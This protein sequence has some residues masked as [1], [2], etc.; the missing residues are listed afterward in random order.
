MGAGERKTPL[1]LQRACHVFHL[2][3]IDSE[4]LEPLEEEDMVQELLSVAL[5][6][7]DGHGEMALATL[8]VAMNQLMPSCSSS[9]KKLGFDKT[10]KFFNKYV[11]Q[12]GAVVETRGEKNHPWIVM[13]PVEKIQK[14]SE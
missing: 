10:T 9:I 13:A 2:L 1:A 12:M 4:T 5:S 14:I 7:M 11:S 3:G 8:V 6:V